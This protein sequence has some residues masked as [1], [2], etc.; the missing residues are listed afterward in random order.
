MKA[1]IF[2]EHS[3]VLAHWWELGAKAR[4]VVYLD[5]HLDLQHVGA[6]RLARLAGCRSVE[7]VKALEKPHA[8]LPDGQYSYSLEDFLYPAARLGLIDRLIWVAPPH[9]RTS[10][11]KRAIQQ[12][13]QMDGVEPKE[14]YGFRKNSGG[15]I[16]GRV[17]GLD[18][19]VCD[20]LHL[21]RIGLPAD[22][23]IDIDADYFVAVPGDKAWV[24]PAAVF[25]VLRRLPSAAEPVTISRSVG[26][27]FMPLRYRFIAEYL[28]ALWENRPERAHYARLFGCEAGLQTGE[29]EAAV[30]GCRRELER[31]PDCAAT[32]YLL[33]MAEA[34]A[35][36]AAR[37]QARAGE[38][39]PAYRSDLLSQACGLRNRMLTVN[40]SSVLG[41]EQ[42]LASGPDPGS[43]GAG[44]AWVALGLIYCV[45][46]DLQR[47]TGCY[48]HASASLGEHPELAMELGRLL[49][50][51]GRLD[52]A[53]ACLRVAL[54]DDKPRT[55]AH[56]LLAQI[57]GASG[58]LE[59]AR[60]HLQLASEAAPAWP[61]LLDLL[62]QV[63]ARL[64]NQVQ[65]LEYRSQCNAQRVQAEQLIQRLA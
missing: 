55:G 49:A 14:L 21:E 53:E 19:A 54:R 26:S 65:A 10:Y 22:P 63:H 39:S 7:Q 16:E 30:L 64:G 8:L 47:A 58:L 57:R 43:R 35:A 24:D 4:T 56:L 20:Y 32:W 45:F 17:L 6:E 31:H 62:A 37:C 33:G 13:Q 48:E 38:L 51:S 61:H 28:A 29:R 3:S 40:L 34:D 23:L 41:L 50:G 1:L 5:A 46:G 59:E 44:L 18:L 36:E 9:V 11:A 27:G 42:Q 12:L 60:S 52:E 15:W 2:E 25:E